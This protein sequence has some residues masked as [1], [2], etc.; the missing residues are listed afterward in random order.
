VEAGRRRADVNLREGA[1]WLLRQWRHSLY[2]PGLRRD[3]FVVIGVAWLPLLVIT[4]VEGRAIGSG[5]HESF[6][7]DLNAQVRLLVAL[8]MLIVAEPLIHCRSRYIV[9]PFLERRLVT[10][11]DEPRFNALVDQ[12]EEMRTS[13][14]V[15]IALAIITTVL[16]G[17]IWHQN[18][19]L[20]SG[21]WY[22]SA[23][24]DGG[25]S[26]T[27]GGWWYVFVSLNVFRFVLLRWYYRLLVWYQ[28]LWHVSRLKLNLNPL[29]PDRTGG[30]GFLALSVAA[31][32]VGFLA[33]TTALAAR[34]GGRILHD[35]ASLDSFAAEMWISPILLTLLS[36]L[37]L[38]FFSLALI[39]ARLK[40]AVDYGGL[41]TRYV[42]EFGRKWMADP[43]VQKSGLVGSPDIQSLADLSNSYQVVTSVRLLPV[44]LPALLVHTL[45]LGAPFIPLALTRFPLDELIRRVVEK[46]I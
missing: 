6:L 7:E 31:L 41:A 39:R 1:I 29:H 45:M 44:S 2:R 30:L 15:A 24:P 4:L 36:I 21:V 42:D 19:S 17:W 5:V 33:Q 46:V 28:F 40:G 26:L 10:P 14:L 43:Q 32:G 38:S 34:I 16:S 37:P 20:R 11:E 27:V 25:V 13:A 12:A 8:P 3:L 9:G 18:W 23:H 35:G 22:V